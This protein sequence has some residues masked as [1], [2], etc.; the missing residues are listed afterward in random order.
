M[1][2]QTVVC[3][4][5]PMFR[6]VEQWKVCG[7]D[8]KVCNIYQFPEEIPYGCLRRREYEDAVIRNKDRCIHCERLLYHIIGG[9]IAFCCRGFDNRLLDPDVFMRILVDERY[10]C[11]ADL[12]VEK[13]NNETGKE[14]LK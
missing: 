9:R 14:N 12:L 4:G 8:R 3:K 10:P 11:Y 13:L 5:C 6:T 7:I 2:R 1:L